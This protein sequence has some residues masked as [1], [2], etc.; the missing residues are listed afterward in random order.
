MSFTPC[1]SPAP[2]H[3]ATHNHPSWESK[4]SDWLSGHELQPVIFNLC[5]ISDGT[6]NT[7]V[8]PWAGSRWPNDSSVNPSAAWMSILY[9]L[10]FAW[11]K[12]GISILIRDGCVP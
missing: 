11:M 7:K 3:Y 6:V 12:K 10:L 4:C 2:E 1:N 5:F 9:K 8:P